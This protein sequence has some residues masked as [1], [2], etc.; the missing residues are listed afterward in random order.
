MISQKMGPCYVVF[1]GNK[2]GIYMSWHECSKQVLGVSNASFLKYKNYK[3]TV[4]DFNASLGAAT[5][6]HPKLLPDDTCETIPPLDAK[7]GSWKNVAL[8]TLLMLVFDLCLRLSMCR[9]CN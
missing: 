7:N 5:P 9:Q 3:E 4:R 2:H 6:L 1:K 8:I